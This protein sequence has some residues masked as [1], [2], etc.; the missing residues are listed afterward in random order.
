[1]LM[2]MLVHTSNTS[3]RLVLM[4]MLMLMIMP[5]IIPVVGWC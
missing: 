1:M 5:M 3:G 2:L 4:L